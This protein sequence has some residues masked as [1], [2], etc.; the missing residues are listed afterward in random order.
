MPPARALMR[1]V[2]NKELAVAQPIVI[3]VERQAEQPFLVVPAT[4][5]AIDLGADVE[6]RFLVAGLRVVGE[7]LDDALLLGDEQEV[8]EVVGRG[9]LDGTGEFQLG[10]SHLDGQPGQRGGL[11]GCFGTPGR[12]QPGGKN[13][14]EAQAGSAR[15]PGGPDDRGKHTDPLQIRSG[16]NRRCV[17]AGP[18]R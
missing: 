3:R 13:E 10:K 9:H 8:A 18:Q 6:K 1:R 16:G 15:P 4:V 14:H 2:V 12:S 5:R 11:A 17:T 7:R